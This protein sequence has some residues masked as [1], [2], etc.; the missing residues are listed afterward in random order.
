MA[1]RAPHFALGDLVNEFLHR[2]AAC[3]QVG[4]VTHLLA[5][6]VI[7]LQDDE[8][9]FTAIHARVRGE[10]LIDVFAPFGPKALDATSDHGAAVYV[11]RV[12]LTIFQPAAALW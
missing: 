4:D 2:P 5:A 7:K 3:N 12:P 6:N 8:V 11:V 1:I 10:V 9:G